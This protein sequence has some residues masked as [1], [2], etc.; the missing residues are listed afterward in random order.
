MPAPRHRAA[1]R[2]DDTGMTI[3]NWITLVRLLLALVF[4]AMLSAFRITDG[5][6]WFLLGWAFAVFLVAVLTD[7]LDGYLARALDQVTTFGRVLDP[8]VDKVIVLGAFI[9]FASPHFFDA[10]AAP[11]RNVTGVQVWMVLVMLIRELLVSAV[12]SFG[13]SRG[14]NFAADRAGKF[15]MFI[16][17]AT[18]CVVLGQLAWFPRDAYPRMA[19]LS[20]ACVWTTVIVTAVSIVGYVGRAR[21]LLLSAEALGGRRPGPESPAPRAGPEAG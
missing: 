16:Q 5:D 17:S 8:V 18:V 12:R 19:L 20:R 9:Y 4:F 10:A 2:R 11:A 15:K 21:R 7:M 6:T 1:G 14:V 3:A 13:E